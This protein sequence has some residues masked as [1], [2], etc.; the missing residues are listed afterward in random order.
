MDEI[1]KLIPQPAQSGAET[2]GASSAN[3]IAEVGADIDAEQ[4]QNEQFA[5]SEQAAVPQSVQNEQSAQS[6]QAAPAQASDRAGD[7]D[8][9]A[10][11]KKRIKKILWNVFLVVVIA[12]GI[13]SLFG[14]VKEVDPSSGTTLKDAVA[15]ASPA[16]FGIFIAVMAALVLLEVAMY[17]VISKTVTGRIML[18]TSAKCN[19][20]GKYY[21]AVTPFS[22]GGQPM[23]IYYLN[24]KGISGGNASAMV[25]IKYFANM[26]CWI[27]VGGA[28][29]V[30][31]AVNNVLSGV[32]GGT[33]LKVAGWVGIAFNLMPPLFVLFFLVF[34]KIMYKLTVGVVKL[35]AKIKLVKNVD[36]ATVRATKVV[37][38]FKTSFKVMATSP[39]K[40]I[41]LI[42]ICLVHAVLIFS[43]PYFVMR[44]FGCELDGMLLTVM[45]LNAYTIFGVS[46]IPTPGNSGVV[47]GLGALA[48]SVAAG[49]TLAWSV[50]TWRLS[51]FYFFIFVGIGITVYDIIK[52]NRKSRSARQ[53]NK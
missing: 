8:K 5:Q 53:E 14:I 11:K 30:Y 50:L 26:L 17:C 21:D 20:L 15:G 4:A 33:L 22:T 38:D 6:E 10:A 25:L 37:D 9:A 1:E 19:F 48:F 23:Q 32:S 28:C 39:I 24:S 3:N 31:G 12:L 42:L 29:M 2:D 40:L 27:F 35:G 44:V 43:M 34:P 46:F 51:V 49:S 45:A 36:K 52:K 13:L 41:M 16:Y 7:A 47:E 18:S